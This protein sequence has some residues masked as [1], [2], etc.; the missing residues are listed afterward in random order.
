MIQASQENSAKQ[1]IRLLAED[2]AH[3]ILFSS[4]SRVTKNGEAYIN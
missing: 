1:V 3:V 2:Y 4:A